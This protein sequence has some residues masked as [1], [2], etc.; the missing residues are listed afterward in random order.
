[1]NEEKEK[2]FQSGCDDYISKPFSAQNLLQIIE[3]TL[4]KT[5]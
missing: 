2:C 3:K 5:I 4:K 1:M